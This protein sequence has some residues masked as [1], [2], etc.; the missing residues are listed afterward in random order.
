M[1]T[2]LFALALALILC[3][4]LFP[5]DALAG[6]MNFDKWSDGQIPGCT[7]PADKQATYGPFRLGNNEHAY[8]ITCE[9]EVPAEG[10]GTTTCLAH[11]FQEGSMYGQRF[12]VLLE[13]QCE[14]ELHPLQPRQSVPFPY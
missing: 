11:I 14:N 9:N 13:V 12:G 1:K 2:R 7:H 4:G 3:F 8:Q 5:L 6:S 10:G